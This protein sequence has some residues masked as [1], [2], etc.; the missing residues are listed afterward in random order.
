MNRENKFEL[1]EATGRAKK[2]KPIT[3][4]VAAAVLFIL[5]YIPGCFSLEP[6]SDTVQSEIENALDRGFDG[7]IVYVD[8][9]GDTASYAAG[10]KN[11]ENKIPA[12]P[13]SLFKIASISKLYIAAAAT[14]LIYHDSLSLDKTLAD[15]L[16]EY[17]GKIENAHTITLRMMLQHRSGIPDFIHHPDFPWSEPPLGIEEALDIVLDLPADFHPDKKY[18]YSNTN[19]LLIGEILD[20]ILGYSHHQYIKREILMPLEL[21]HTYSLLREVN[22]DEVMSGYF[23]GY[24]PDI[25]ENDYLIPGGSMLATAR[26]V[27]VF[28]RALIDGSLFNTNEQAIYSSI[29]KYEHT[30][31]LPGYQSIARYHKEID[32]VVIQF[33][34]TSG[35]SSWSKSASVY[36]R[37]VRILEKEHELSQ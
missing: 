23:V 29:Y 30:G 35:G 24:D 26:D 31:E 15:Y 37:I 19:Y 4:P 16:P 32:A 27:G 7:I 12:D 5:F 10:W 14:R 6:L 22:M 25:K 36:R 33:I 13:K 20:K 11:R 3:I 8:R 1:S 18:K 21:Y 28:L 2:R 17:A 9:K 34:N